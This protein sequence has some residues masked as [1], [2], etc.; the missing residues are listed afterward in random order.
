[1]F[2]HTCQS[3]LDRAPIGVLCRREAEGDTM[4]PAICFDCRRRIWNINTDVQNGVRTF[5]FENPNARGDPPP[6]VCEPCNPPLH[7][8]TTDQPVLCGAQSARSG[9]SGAKNNGWNC[10]RCCAHVPSAPRH[11]DGIVEPHDWWWCRE[12]QTQCRKQADATP[13][14]QKGQP[15]GLDK[16][17]QTLDRWLL[18]K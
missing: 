17:S 8:N 14:H 10:H 4:T 12:C 18:K 2:C 15:S 1:M 6:D 7:G 13:R 3:T 9:E 11:Y 5:A 16:H